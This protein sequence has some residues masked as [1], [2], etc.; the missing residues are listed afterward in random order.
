[1]SSDKL[2]QPVVTNCPCDSDN[3]IVTGTV[4]HIGLSL[5]S[6]TGRG[7]NRAMKR[8]QWLPFLLLLGLLACGSQAPGP[9]EPTPAGPD[10][11]A[12]VPGTGNARIRA[13]TGDKTGDKRPGGEP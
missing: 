13:A 10:N 11:A 1:M 3:P 7:R 2:S 9:D 12:A 8:P 6:Q 4:T 5:L